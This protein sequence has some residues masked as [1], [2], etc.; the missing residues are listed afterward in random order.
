MEEKQ[1]RIF[2]TSGQLIQE[3]DIQ[4]ASSLF[5]LDAVE[6][7][8]GLYFVKIQRGNDWSSKTFKVIKQ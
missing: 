5:R 3:N 8:A 6:W 2:N 1:I 7:P 4:E